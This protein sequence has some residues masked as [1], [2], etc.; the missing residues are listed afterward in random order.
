MLKSISSLGKVLNKLEQRSINGGVGGNFE[1]CQR[2]CFPAGGDCFE[3]P[4]VPGF[5]ECSLFR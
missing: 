3:H 5:F 4:E 1:S 2:R